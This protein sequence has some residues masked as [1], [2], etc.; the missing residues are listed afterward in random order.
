MGKYGQAVHFF[1]GTKYKPI[2]DEFEQIISGDKS[3]T[4]TKVMNLSYSFYGKKCCSALNSPGMV[5]DIEVEEIEVK[6]DSLSSHENV[7]V[8]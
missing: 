6:V 1:S 3:T 4:I 2:L 5:V 7:F 8:S